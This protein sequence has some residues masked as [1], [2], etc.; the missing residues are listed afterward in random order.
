MTIRRGAWTVAR[1]VWL[2]AM[3]TL[4]G[5]CASNESYRKT[6]VVDSTCP[7]TSATEHCAGDVRHRIGQETDGAFIT[8]IEFDDQGSLHDR[9]L[10]NEA[11]RALRDRASQRPT[12]IVAFAHGWK[13]NASH[14][15]GNVREF[16]RLL[17]GLQ[18]S[19][20]N[21]QVEGVYIGWRGLSARWEP[22]KLLSFWKRKSAGARVGT[23]GAIDLIAELS[24]IRAASV[25]GD[26]PGHLLIVAGHSFGGAVVFN[27]TQHLLRRELVQAQECVASTD[28]DAEP[29][30]RM[31]PFAD[32]RVQ[33]PRPAGFL[34]ARTCGH[35]SASV[36]DFVVI[37]NPAFENTRYDP[38]EA[39][40][41]QTGFAAGQPPILAVF[42]SKGDGATKYAFPVGRLISTLTNSYVDTAQA[43][44]DRRA[45]GHLRDK[46]THEL[47]LTDAASLN[48]SL[49][50]LR[51]SDA[52]VELAGM[53]ERAPPGGWVD[54]L[55]DRNADWTLDAVS[56]KRSAQNPA[57]DPFSPYMVVSVQKGI[58]SNHSDIWG[59]AFTAFV[60]RLVRARLQARHGA[61]CSN[62]PK[63][64]GGD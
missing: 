42:M 9:E 21:W 49:R 37:V 54:F 11:L 47:V 32:T 59:D 30:I 50:N 25:N 44:R 2:L 62:Q 43:A 12:L 13:H 8:Y 38:L 7:G 22:A 10:S 56:L 1:S 29:M 28:P 19:Q 15:S 20:S 63:G 23:D 53:I 45:V 5:G 61:V 31:I 36:A 41:R 6:R 26:G 33:S 58:I 52:S 17:A 39:R 64:D 27:A 55:C 40:S 34:E 4:L 48:H 35:L 18:R 57:A 60:Q 3:L 16:Q 14:R 51:A 24:A 46:W